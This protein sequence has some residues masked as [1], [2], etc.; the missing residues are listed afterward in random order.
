M[1]RILT[2][3]IVDVVAPLMSAARPQ[4]RFEQ[5]LPS[6]KVG[7]GIFYLFPEN[8]AKKT[9]KVTIVITEKIIGSQRDSVFSV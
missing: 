6:K 2:I 7:A 8:V 4:G 9:R 5:E 1:A 3:R